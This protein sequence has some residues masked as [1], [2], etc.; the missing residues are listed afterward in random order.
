MISGIKNT[1]YV[2][3]CDG[4][5]DVAREQNGKLVLNECKKYS[6]KPCEMIDSE[7]I[8]PMG[9]FRNCDLCS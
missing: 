7:R 1:D 6:P 2:I 9:K 8:D 5:N 4:L 3:A